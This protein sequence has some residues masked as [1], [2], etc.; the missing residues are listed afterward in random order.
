MKYN[1]VQFMVD[2][3]MFMSTKKVIVHP[4]TLSLVLQR[5]TKRFLAGQNTVVLLSPFRGKVCIFLNCCSKVDSNK[6]SKGLVLK[7]LFDIQMFFIST[8]KL[9]VNHVKLVLLHRNG[10]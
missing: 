9:I 2:I 3:Q 10:S 6:I 7:L 5:L 4:R 8:Q 1:F